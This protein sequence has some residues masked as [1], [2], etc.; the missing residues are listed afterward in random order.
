MTNNEES[1]NGL[2]PRNHL[3]VSLTLALN[4]RVFDWG[5]S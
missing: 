1:T 4:L 2:S 5:W 3:M